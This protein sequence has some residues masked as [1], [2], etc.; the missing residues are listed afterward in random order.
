MQYKPEK[1]KILALA[2]QR[3]NQCK[4]F[5]GSLNDLYIESLIYHPNDSTLIKAITNYWIK[6]GGSLRSSI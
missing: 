4:I 1:Q 3:I 2:K 5:N 6:S